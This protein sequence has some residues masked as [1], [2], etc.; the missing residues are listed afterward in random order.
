MSKEKLIELAN[1][2]WNEMWKVLHGM[3]SAKV[4]NLFTQAMKDIEEENAAVRAA[5]RYVVKLYIAYDE[6][7]EDEKESQTDQIVADLITRF[8]K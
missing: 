6:L 4:Q 7:E 1:A 3:P 5:L 2:D 8:K